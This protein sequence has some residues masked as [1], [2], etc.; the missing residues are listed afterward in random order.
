MTRPRV[1]FAGTPALMAA[2]ARALKEPQGI[3][4]AVVP[5][6][7]MQA[8]FRRPAFALLALD[9]LAPVIEAQPAASVFLTD[10]LDI[11]ILGPDLPR[12]SLRAAVGRMR[13][14]FAADP[15][16]RATGPQTDRFA[17]WFDL[18]REDH[19]RAL[20]ALV[21]AIDQRS[22]EI[23][24]QK[25]A[26][27]INDQPITPQRLALLLAD[28]EHLDIAPLLDSQRAVRVG[29]N[30][31]AD[32]LFE[33]YFFSVERL[34]RKI[35]PDIS[36]TSDRWLFQ[37]FSRALDRH[38]LR[39]LERVLSRRLRL[40]RTLAINLNLDSVITDT[41]DRFT[42]SLRPGQALIV[43]AQAVDVF[44]DVAAYLRVRDHLHAQGH[45]ITIDALT[46]RVL[47]AVDLVPLA[48]DFYK[49][50][51]IP[52]SVHTVADEDAAA[53]SALIKAIGVDR[54]I[55]CHVESKQ[56][57]AWGLKAG[58]RCFQGFFIDTLV[59][60]D[61]LVP[62]GATT[63]N[64]GPAATGVEATPGNPGAQPMS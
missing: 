12:D 57:M 30:R 42:R 61:T 23:A 64:G 54:V 38:M 33:E 46:P 18:E 3:Q 17:R 7:Q 59:A 14:L 40:P 35:A 32:V 5:L 43:E 2:V 58:V 37:D 8:D 41:F 62:A 9:G 52:D 49:L 48:A 6:S 15:L 11:M 4:A 34:R 31:T 29:G 28:M 44:A 25:G 63:G 26:W 16:A 22:A 55:C 19:R 13:R 21:D 56:A 27:T 53:T 50:A 39:V 47:E 36:L 1:P 60:S 10:S 45:R 20:A 24:L 51:W